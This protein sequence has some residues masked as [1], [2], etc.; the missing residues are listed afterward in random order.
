MSALFE[1]YE[2]FTRDNILTLSAV[3]ADNVIVI[4]GYAIAEP[5]SADLDANYH[6]LQ[7]YGEHQIGQI[8]P[9]IL[10]GEL[11]RLRA[12]PQPDAPVGPRGNITINPE[13][14]PKVVQPIVD[15]YNA[16]AKARWEKL[17]ADYEREDAEWNS[18]EAQAERVRQW[19]QSAL[20]QTNFLM[21]P[22][23][24]LTDAE[25]QQL[26]ELRAAIWAIPNN[27]PRGRQAETQ[28]LSAARVGEWFTG[29]RFA[30]ELQ[31][32]ESLTKPTPPDP[33][34]IFH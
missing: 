10:E 8:E 22:D 3:P 23:A 27:I 12:N 17:I 15:F 32:F 24:P 34:Q 29:A 1:P 4:N 28:A 25:R 30:D 33:R 6:A 26:L 16:T 9:N 19:K 11:M 13:D 20:S 14:F 31:R 5:F 18:P 2:P 21:F 7:W